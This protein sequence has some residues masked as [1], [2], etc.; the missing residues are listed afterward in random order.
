KG[1]I[2]EVR[3]YKRA[4]SDTEIQAIYQQESGDASQTVATLIISPSGGNYSGSVSVAMQTATSGASIYYSTDGS[5]PTQSSTPYTAT[6]AFT[7]S[8]TVKAKAFKNGSNASAQAS[9]SFT[10]SSL[11]FSFSLSNSGVQSVVAASS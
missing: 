11:P 4:L 8:T 9:A 2:D 1:I 7:S 3:V 5:T 10:I 6:I